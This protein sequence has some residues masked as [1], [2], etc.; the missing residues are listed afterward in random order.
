MNSALTKRIPL[1]LTSLLCSAN[2]FAAS[3]DKAQDQGCCPKETEG[4]CSIELANG[5][6]GCTLQPDRPSVD[7]CHG[8]EF[9]ASALYWRPYVEGTEFAWTTVGN[10]NDTYPYNGEVLSVKSDF[11][12]GFQVG[13]GYLFCNDGWRGDLDFTFHQGH[14]KKN[15]SEEWNEVVTPT[16]AV[17]FDDQS[18]LVYDSAQGKLSTDYYRLALSLTRGTFASRLLVINP[19]L[20]LTTTWLDIY[21]KN[22]FSSNAGDSHD[23]LTEKKR[24]KTWQIGPTG[25]LD[26]RLAFGDSG[27]SLTGEWDMTLGFGK[28]EI[29]QD[30]FWSADPEQ[31]SSYI[32]NDVLRFAPSA[33]ALLGLQYDRD[34]FD[35]TQHLTVMFGL[36]TNVMW[37]GNRTISYGTVSNQS[38]VFN[39]QNDNTFALIGLTMAFNYQF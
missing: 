17:Y 35:H 3:K 11:D 23:V 4:C 10:D 24:S 29:S 28:T 39:L 16:T 7:L 33:H 36:D 19:G 8:F 9:S 20:G 6:M 22:K 12:W 5:R 13:I 18:D 27:F 30:C 32:T 26:T 15:F 21:Q 25:S 38:Y 37:S 31:Y 1:V 34:Y 2:V 14:G